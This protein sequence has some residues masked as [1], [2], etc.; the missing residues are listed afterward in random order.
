MFGRPV[1]VGQTVTAVGGVQAQVQEL[2][3]KGTPMISGVISER[4]HF[5]FRSR[6]ARIIWLVQISSEMWEYD[7]N[8]DLYFEKFLNQFVDPIFDRWKALS[9]THSLTVVFFARTLYLDGVDPS[10]TPDLWCKASLQTRSDGV[11]YQDFFK[12]VLENSAEL[13]K[14]TQLKVLKKEFWA[15]P[16]NVGWNIERDKPYGTA[17]GTYSA[18]CFSKGKGVQPIAVPSDALT[19]NVLEAINT[20]LNLLDKH[21]IDRD[22]QRTGNSIVMISPGVGIFKVK[23]TIALITKQRMMDTGIGLDFISLSQ[24]PL[25]FVPLFLFDCKEEGL[26]D[27]YVVPQWINVCYVDCRKD[28]SATV[29][30]AT[31]GAVAA[32]LGPGSGISIGNVKAIESPYHWTG[33]EEFGGV[34]TTRRNSD[35]VVEKVYHNIHSITNNTGCKKKK[36]QDLFVRDDI[37]WGEGFTPQPFSSILRGHLY[38]KS[39]VDPASH[40]GITDGQENRT[41]EPKKSNSS[42]SRLSLY[43]DGENLG[44]TDRIPGRTCSECISAVDVKVNKSLVHAFALPAPLKR[45]LLLRDDAVVYAA[46]RTIQAAI[47]NFAMSVTSEWEKEK[48]EEGESEALVTATPERLK[49]HPSSSASGI[50]Q[51][52]F[53]S[54]REASN[55][56]SRASKSA[57]GDSG[58]DNDRDGKRES[59]DYENEDGFNLLRDRS[60][61]FN[62]DDYY[63]GSKNSYGTHSAVVSSNVNNSG[64][65]SRHHTQPSKRDRERERE[66]DR[67]IRTKKGIDRDSE[68]DRERDSERDRERDRDR[69]RGSSYSMVSFMP[70][71][72]AQSGTYVRCQ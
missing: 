45:V 52:G 6:S 40:F 34:R 32:G 44:R 63:D 21:Y 54:F 18:P 35:K 28:S 8:G 11:L 16:K 39:G 29:E 69:E 42:N 67:E 33:L 38:G 55:T 23:P 12:V 71:E 3:I 25:H 30:N 64:H 20:T 24:P 27:F 37:V 66:R 41:G 50:P 14:V 61:S 1:H 7:Q 58:D 2:G 65:N 31:A 36:S 68:R 49:G 53:I 13:D 19:G 15:F 5:V 47:H 57:Q 4:T 17:T 60:V 72:P 62:G 59:L 46:K 56:I 43:T 51:W 70:S 10:R 26:G 22:L 9:V 48:E